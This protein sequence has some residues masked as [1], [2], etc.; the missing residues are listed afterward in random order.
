MSLARLRGGEWISIASAV[1]LFAL[2]FFH[3]FGV[4]LVNTSNLLF[5]VQSVEPGKSAWEALEYTP[6]VLAITVIATLAAAA[7]GLLNASPRRP[8][9]L[10]LLVAMLGFV[11]MLSILFLIVNPPTFSVEKTITSEGTVQLPIFL[12]LLAAAGITFGGWR[13]IREDADDGSGYNHPHAADSA[14]DP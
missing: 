12:A 14:R 3:W 1:L 5:G 8:L 11:S 2:T 7:L 9:L 6:I 10:N 4:K 13:A